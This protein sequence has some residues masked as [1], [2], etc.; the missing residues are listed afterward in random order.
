M[1][2]YRFSNDKWVETKSLT[3]NDVALI[4]DTNSKTV[5][6]W[7]GDFSTSKIKQLAVSNLET[8]RLKYPNFKFRMVTAEISPDIKTVLNEAQKD[9]ESVRK[10]TESDKILFQK[11]HLFFSIVSLVFVISSLLWLIILFEIQQNNSINNQ[12]SIPIAFNL[13]NALFKGISLL[14][15]LSIILNTG[16]LTLNLIQKNYFKGI[17]FAVAV[18]I[19]LILVLWYWNYLFDLLLV[20]QTVIDNIM[21]ISIPKSIFNEILIYNSIIIVIIIYFILA[22]MIFKQKKNQTVSETPTS[23]I[24]NSPK[25]TT[26]TK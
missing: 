15:F 2:L 10:N 24:D 12:I 19:Q 7:E 25:A 3:H 23:S 4:I 22:S 11:I 8:M 20:F 21:V 9:S 14:I 6:I 1:D 13:I 16:N 18:I 17:N 5:Y 26:Q